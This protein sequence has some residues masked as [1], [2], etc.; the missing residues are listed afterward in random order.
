[1]P[2]ALGGGL[3]K[4]AGESIVGERNDL[5]VRKSRID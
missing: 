2:E 5:G 1:M 3:E 4:E